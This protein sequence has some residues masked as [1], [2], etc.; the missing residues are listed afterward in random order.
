MRDS[1]SSRDLETVIAIGGNELEGENG[2]SA[3]EACSCCWI[4]VDCNDAVVEGNQRVCRICHLSAKESGM[5]M[6]TAELVELGCGCKGELGVAH[7]QCAEAWFRVKGNR[8]CE[9]CGEAARNVSGVC[10]QRFMEEW[11]EGRRI[12]GGNGNSTADGSRRRCLQ[13]QPFCNLLMACLVIAFILPW[14]FRVN[15][16]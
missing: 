7:R 16:F 13:G 3:V 12:D 11:N 1:N 2:K 4:E 15:L 8:L 10:D 14:F 9:I 6:S 5:T